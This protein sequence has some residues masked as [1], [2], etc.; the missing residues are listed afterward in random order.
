MAPLNDL[1][2]ECG[3]GKGK[4][5]KP[6]WKWNKIHQDAFD[7]CKKMLANEVKLAFPDFTKP[8]YLYLDAIQYPVRRNSRTGGLSTRFLHA[9]TQLSPTKLHCL[10]E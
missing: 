1:A 7:S 5:A 3:K 6:T 2:A 10:G 9:K 8:F 4:K